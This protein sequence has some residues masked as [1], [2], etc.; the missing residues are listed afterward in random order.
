[1]LLGDLPLVGL[2]PGLTQRHINKPQKQF[3]SS[4]VS[5]LKITKDIGEIGGNV[6]CLTQTIHSSIN[7]AGTH[8]N[9]VINLGAGSVAQRRMLTDKPKALRSICR[10][11]GRGLQE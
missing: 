6:F 8:C 7:S 9:K 2:Q 10:I 4:L 3:K 1:M 11:R 5:T